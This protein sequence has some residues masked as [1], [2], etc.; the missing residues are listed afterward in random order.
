MF[1]CAQSPGTRKGSILQNLNNVISASLNAIG[2]CVCSHVRSIQTKNACSGSGEEEAFV[3]AF[4]AKGEDGDDGT[5][6]HD[7]H[8]VEDKKDEAH[9]TDKHD[10]AL[11]ED[12]PLALLAGVGAEEVHK[13]T[14]AFKHE[15][16]AFA[17]VAGAGEAEVYKFSPDIKGQDGATAH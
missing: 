2:M 1:T 3:V 5:A 7:T 13:G 11:D 9:A 12:D 4:V 15:E 6:A 16:Q 14:L 17:I 8:D 10:V